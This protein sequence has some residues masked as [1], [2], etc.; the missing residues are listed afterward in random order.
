MAADFTWLV[1][2]YLKLSHFMY[3]PCY[4]FHSFPPRFDLDLNAAKDDSNSEVQAK[5]RLAREKELLQTEHNE[6]K[7]KYKVL[8]MV[9]VH[10]LTSRI[11]KMQ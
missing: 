3:Y 9:V 8:N 10:T 4:Y 1:S 5:V 7:E 2:K 6:L 11:N